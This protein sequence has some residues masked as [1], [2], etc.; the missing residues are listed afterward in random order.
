MTV[1]SEKKARRIIKNILKENKH[2]KLI[3]LA[4]AISEKIKCRRKFALKIVTLLIREN[5]IRVNG[6]LSLRWFGK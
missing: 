3:P 5:R 4:K 1:I 6:D 2:I